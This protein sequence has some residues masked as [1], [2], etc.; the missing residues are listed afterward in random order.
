MLT[1]NESGL[2]LGIIILLIRHTIYNSKHM[3]NIPQWE[4]QSYC[5]V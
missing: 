5:R 4:I 1:E 3:Q 2:G